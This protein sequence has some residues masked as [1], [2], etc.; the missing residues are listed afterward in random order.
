MRY[1]CYFKI[2]LHHIDLKYLPNMQFYI[3]L[4]IVNHSI[5][6]QIF[7]EYLLCIFA[8]LPETWETMIIKAD[9]FSAVLVC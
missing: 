1:S 7:V 2:K 9:I 3:I 4:I 5:I 6:Q 8:T